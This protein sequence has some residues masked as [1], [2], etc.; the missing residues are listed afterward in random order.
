MVP[1]RVWNPETLPQSPRVLLAG[2]IWQA[3]G[4]L[5]FVAIFH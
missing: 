3:P 2:Y 1:M 5:L 4:L